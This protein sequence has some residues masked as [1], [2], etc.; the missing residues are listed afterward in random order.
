[1]LKNREQRVMAFLFL[2][3][4]FVLFTAIV[5]VPS[6]VAFLYSL[7]RWDGLGDAEWVGL[8]NFRRL[9]YQRELFL[10][11]FRHNV[12][13]M[14]V[15]GLITLV[16]ALFFAALLHGR[17]RGARVFRVAFFFPNVISAVAISLLWVLIYSTT[18]FGVLNSVL[19]WL[20]YEPVAF[21]ESSKLIYSLVPM[22]VWCRVGFF[23]ILFL[24]AMQNIPESLYEAARMDG[25]SGRQSFFNVTLPLIRD[26]FT[27]G[28]VFM[29]IG[30]LKIFDTIWVMENQ[31]PKSESHVIATL[32]YEKVFKEY[33]IGYGSA[34]AV[35]LFVIVVA[36]T[37]I[38]LRLMKGERLEY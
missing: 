25:A 5:A 35:L 10:E 4:A 32:M 6:V 7:Q 21:L 9:F 22:M 8:A 14:V 24:A 20:G 3:P 18:D 13:L 29:V 31:R 33:N 26:V 2:A 16:I 19:R 12:F 1:M 36:A 27:A 23:M 28:V 17:I 38:T 11:A 34:I 30:G 15:P 37:L